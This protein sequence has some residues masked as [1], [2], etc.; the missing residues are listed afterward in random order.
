MAIWRA[1][2]ALRRAARQVPTHNERG[3]RHAVTRIAAFVRLHASCR[4]DG[5]FVRNRETVSSAMRFFEEDMQPQ[6]QKVLQV[7]QVDG[8]RGLAS[9][10]FTLTE[11]I[12]D[13]G[14]PADLPASQNL[15]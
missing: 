6:P 4:E 7:L 14:N 13:L 12:A 11:K 8:E 2:Q 9:A 1:A 10:L 5:W 3:S 15:D